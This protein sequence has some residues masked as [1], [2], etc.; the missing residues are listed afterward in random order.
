[1]Q[2]ASLLSQ[3]GTP[4]QNDLDLA[5]LDAAEAGSNCLHQR[6]FTEECAD[7]GFV[8]HQAPSW[9]TTCD[10]DQPE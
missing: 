8:V 10:L 3:V 5:W 2:R 9:H 6:L 4:W 1:V 7:G